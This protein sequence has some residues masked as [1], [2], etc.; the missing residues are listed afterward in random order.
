[1]FRTI[2]S[3]LTAAVEYELIARNPATGKR[4]RVNADAPERPWLDTAGQIAALLDAPGEVDA[5]SPT[6]QRRA[7]LATLMFAGLRVG[8]CWRCAGATSIWLPGG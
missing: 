1:L 7:V 8:S 6:R 4:R 2:P 3:C 5:E